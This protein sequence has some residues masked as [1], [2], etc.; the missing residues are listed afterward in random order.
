MAKHAARVTQ[1]HQC[2]WCQARVHHSPREHEAALRAHGARPVPDGTDTPS[3]VGSTPTR[4]TG[5]GDRPV[6]TEDGMPDMTKEATPLGSGLTSLQIVMEFSQRSGGGWGGKLANKFNPADPDLV[7]G[8]GAGKLLVDLIDPKDKPAGF[9]GAITHRG[10]AKGNGSEVMD[11][12]LTALHEL[13]NDIDSFV[14][15]AFCKGDKGFG[16]VTG[17]VWR[18]FDTSTGGSKHLG[19]VRVD[20]STTDSSV[21]AAV[22]RRVGAHPTGTWQYSINPTFGRHTTVA[23]LGNL[24]RPA[25]GA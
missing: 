24:F 15:G 5:P 25:L 22:L 14:L 23:G 2:G 4:A 17:I 6:N 8:V 1:A 21:A 18:I 19:N 20:I 13:D 11:I 9:S 10:D 12:D 3:P 7:A 16:R